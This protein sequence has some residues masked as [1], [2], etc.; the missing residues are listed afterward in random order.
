MFQ[1]LSNLLF[2]AVEDVSA[3]ISGPKP[4]VSEVDDEGWLL[5]SVPGDRNCTTLS[6]DGAEVPSI[7]Q[8]L[9]HSECQRVESGCDIATPPSCTGDPAP[10]SCKRRRTRAGRSQAVCPPSSRS[11][12]PRLSPDSP[13]PLGSG[14]ANAL[15]D[16]TSCGLDES[17]FITPPPCFTAEGAP[18][19]ASP[20]E[21]LL[22]EHPS[23]SVYVS[24][25]NLEQSTANMAD[26]VSRMTESTPAPVPT[27]L[28]RG[29]ACQA[30]PLA[31]V[32]QVSRVQRAKARVER[33][34]L[35]RGRMQRQN[36]VRQQIPRT[37]AHTRSSFLHQPCQRNLC[38]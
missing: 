8:S 16:P 33:R 27:R 10:F 37:V 30:V 3:E 32:T 38:H 24:S 12:R 11:L 19:E 18:A 36:R 14:G 17:W 22:I 6:E 1:R 31:K 23:M 15:S 5:V 28:V 21:D 29:S 35:G 34:H 26:S 7:A 20:M 25:S 4:C 13:S 9:P 2:G